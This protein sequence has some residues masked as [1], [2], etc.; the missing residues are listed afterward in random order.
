M[1]P[2][3]ERPTVFDAATQERIVWLLAYGN[4]AATACRA[5]GVTFEA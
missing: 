5:A 1:K 3:L 2:V 4:F